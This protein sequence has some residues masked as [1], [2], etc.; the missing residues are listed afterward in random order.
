MTSSSISKILANDTV[1]I[2]ASSF[3][4][5][6]PLGETLFMANKKE[7]V[8]GTGEVRFT[9]E[10]EHSFKFTNKFTYYYLVRQLILD[11]PCSPV[12]RQTRKIH[13]F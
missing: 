6:G 1:K 13:D 12:S 2:S 11:W 7:I 4:I 8:F 10:Y 5:T 9:G 3:N